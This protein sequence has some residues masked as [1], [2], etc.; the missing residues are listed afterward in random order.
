MSSF[1]NYALAGL[2]LGGL[3]GIVALPLTMVWRTTGVFDFAV[4]G[5]VVAAG[6]VAADVGWPM[7]ALAGIGVAVALSAVTAVFFL[8]FKA[9][10]GEGEGL[11]MS[12]GTFGLVLA[13]TAGMLIWL[14]TEPRFMSVVDGSWRLGDIVLTKSRAISFGLSCILLVGLVIGLW[15]TSLGLRTRASAVEGSHAELLGVPVRL[16]QCGS[17]LVAGVVCGIV[18][19]MAV[20][21]VGVTYTS[22]VE[23]SI[24]ALS[25][26]VLLGLRGPG[27]AFAGGIVL[28]LFESLSQGYVGQ[29]AAG[30]LPSVLLLVVLASGITTRGTA[31]A[32]R[33]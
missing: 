28:G 26:A 14:G 32:V 16:V 15:R 27:T 33:P 7:G 11:G 17:I 25:A 1:L 30:V 29:T 4:G 10:Q 19:V 13:I 31:M 23:F 22:S 12:L 21:T 18:G 5:Y 20:A 24:L 8:L 2:M 6:I 3:Y 9:T